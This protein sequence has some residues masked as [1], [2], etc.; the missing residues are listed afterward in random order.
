MKKTTILLVLALS[1][2]LLVAQEKCDLYTS[3]QDNYWEQSSVELK[4]IAQTLNEKIVIDPAVKY[5]TIDGWGGCFNEIGW[6]ALSYLSDQEKK[7]VMAALFDPSGCVFTICRMPIGSSDYGLDYYS[8][9][10]SAGDYKMKY[11]SI[12]RDK[13]CM[14]PYI[15]AAMKYQPEL[16]VWGSPW[17]PPAWMK[18]N[19]KYFQGQLNQDEKNLQAYALYFSKYVEEYR[20]EGINVFAVHVQNEPLHLPTFPSCGWTGQQMAN[21]IGKYLGPHFQKEKLNAEI[22]L[23]TLN[24]DSDKDEYKLFVVPS[25]SDPNTAKYITGVGFQ[26]Y[27]DAAVEATVDN[28]LDKKIMQ[29]ETKCGN[30][31]NSWNYAFETYEQMEWYLNRNATV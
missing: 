5:Q 7:K 3:S 4:N 10:D 20:K 12:E 8:F 13:K 23:G 1:V 25:L 18:T 26:W 14:I 17:T 21:F 15:K 30:G 9:N 19:G 2:K 31:D 11:F 16:R 28:F 22:W 29:T 24:G 6:Q 27:G